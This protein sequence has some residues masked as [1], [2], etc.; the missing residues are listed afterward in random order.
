MMVNQ[1]N[2]R[3]YLPQYRMRSLVCNENIFSRQPLTD[4]QK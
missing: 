1:V 3:L 2:E 4:W